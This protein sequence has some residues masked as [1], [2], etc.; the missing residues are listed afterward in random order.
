RPAAGWPWPGAPKKKLTFCPVGKPGG[1]DTGKKGLLTPNKMAAT[2]RTGAS[3]K[4]Q[5]RTSGG[6][7]LEKTA[8]RPRNKGSL[9]LKRN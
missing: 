9:R 1:A 4:P 3:P 7:K 5:L 2:A 6:K 8:T